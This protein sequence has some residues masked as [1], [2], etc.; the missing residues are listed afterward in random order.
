M[1]K[2]YAWYWTG[3]QNGGGAYSRDKRSAV[4]CKW[5]QEGVDALSGTETI[6]QESSIG[7][8]PQISVLWALCRGA[9]YSTSLTD[10]TF[11]V[12]KNKPDVYN[13]TLV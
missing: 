13:R 12:D 3:S 1:T 11:M 5:I 7:G 10:F 9:V 2:K 8:C 6:L 4:V